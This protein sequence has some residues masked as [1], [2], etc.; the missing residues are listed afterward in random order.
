MSETLLDE[1]WYLSTYLANK[2]DPGVTLLTRRY[3]V[4]RTPKGNVKVDAH[5]DALEFAS[6]DAMADAIEE[7][8]W[9]ELPEAADGQPRYIPAQITKA[10]ERF[11]A[12]AA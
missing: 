9:Q 10:V 4:R 12:V 8:G 5:T 2:D 7:G 3:V 1:T 11:K 6:A